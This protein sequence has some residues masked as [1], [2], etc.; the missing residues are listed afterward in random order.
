MPKIIPPIMY[1]W[2]WMIP[3]DTAETLRKL[4]HSISRNNNKNALIGYTKYRYKI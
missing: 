4:Q 2:L 1:G 3:P